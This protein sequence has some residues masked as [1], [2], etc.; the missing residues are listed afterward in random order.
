MSLQLSPE[1]EST[2]TPL[3]RI[4]YSAAR[5]AADQVSVTEPGAELV[6]AGSRGWAGSTHRVAVTVPV[7]VFPWPSETVY[8]NESVPSLPK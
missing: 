7:A 4:R 8:V 2:T 5:A 3:R 1:V 6:M